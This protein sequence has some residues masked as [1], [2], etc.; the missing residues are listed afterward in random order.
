MQKYL[1]LKVQPLHSAHYF[2][3]MAAVS[4]THTKMLLVPNLSA[5][6]LEYHE[7]TKSNK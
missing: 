4:L 2:I 1:W 7:H 3:I 6:L 5:V